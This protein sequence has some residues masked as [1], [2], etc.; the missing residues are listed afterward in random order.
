M[1]IVYKNKIILFNHRICCHEIK[2]D[3]CVISD[4]R[5]GMMSKSVEANLYSDGQHA[6]PHDLT[7]YVGAW[8]FY[9]QIWRDTHKNDNVG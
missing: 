3:F 1:Q 8:K 5:L 4:L 9:D 6:K 7:D 2:I